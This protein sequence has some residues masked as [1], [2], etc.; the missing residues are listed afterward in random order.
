MSS[1]G[2][3]SLSGN[4]LSRGSHSVLSILG[5]YVFKYVP[6]LASDRFEFLLQL[7][8]FIQQ[9]NG[10]VFEIVF[11]IDTVLFFD[12]GQRFTDVTYLL[13][14]NFGT[15]DGIRSIGDTT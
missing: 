3:I 1:G 15:I 5:L 7:S 9:V 6:C 13:W 11:R 2:I 12:R 4:R 10:Q 8:I 14:W